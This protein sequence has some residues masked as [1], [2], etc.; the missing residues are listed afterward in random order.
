MRERMDK[1]RLVLENHKVDAYFNGHLHLLE[2]RTLNGV[3][4]IVSGGGGKVKSYARNEKY[5]NVPGWAA[6]GSDVEG[7][8]ATLS[9]DLAKG[10]VNVRYLD[11]HG[12][13]LFRCAPIA[14][15][16][17]MFPG[18]SLNV[19]QLGLRPTGVRFNST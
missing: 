1:I 12:Q 15:P 18:C 16:K 6:N 14:N 19:P 2:H 17:K 11:S 10:E 5:A 3:T 13:E 8:F 9:V 4:Y 7:G